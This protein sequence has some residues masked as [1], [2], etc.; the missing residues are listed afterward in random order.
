MNSSQTH[1]NPVVNFEEIRVFQACTCDQRFNLTQVPNRSGAVAHLALCA[2]APTSLFLSFH[3]VVVCLFFSLSCFFF[4]LSFFL[5]LFS[6][7]SLSLLFFSLSLFLSSLSQALFFSRSLF[8]SF[9][10]FLN[11]FF[12]SHGTFF[13]LMLNSLRLLSSLS[14]C[15]LSLCFL[16]FFT[17]VS[18]FWRFVTLFFLL[19]ISHVSIVLVRLTSHQQ[20][21]MS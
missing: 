7:F 1:F 19:L 9:S 13:F 21:D 20:L 12:F 14:F 5:T 10:F 4:S 18:L 6:F 16:F 11:F 15:F 2:C 17:F 3:T 8:F